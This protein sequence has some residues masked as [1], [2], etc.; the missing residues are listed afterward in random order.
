VGQS[1]EENM[2]FVIS[3]VSIRKEKPAFDKEIYIYVAPSP[4]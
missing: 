3:K 2:S 4:K 1:L